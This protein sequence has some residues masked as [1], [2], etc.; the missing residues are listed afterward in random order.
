ED[1]DVEVISVDVFA[2]QSGALERNVLL[3]DGD[4]VFV[5]RAATIYVFGEVKTPGAYP[6]QKDTTVLQALSLAGGST[7]AGALNRTRVIR[8]VDG[9]KQEIRVDM[10][11]IVR[12]G[13]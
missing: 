10:N 12:A 9:E 3:Q 13:D 6:V 11:E 7:D 5:P 1:A 4:T 2:L 8:V